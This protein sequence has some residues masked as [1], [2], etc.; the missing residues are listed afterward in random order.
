[1]VVK[2]FHIVSIVPCPLTMTSQKNSHVG[3]MLGSLLGAMAR[4]CVISGHVQLFMKL[5]RLFK[6]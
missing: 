3:S 2:K 1:M 4:L 6:N 5:D